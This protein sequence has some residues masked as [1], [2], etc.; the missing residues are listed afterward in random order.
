MNTVNFAST[1]HDPKKQLKHLIEEVGEKLRTPFST[2]SVVYT[3]KTHPDEVAQLE[4]IGYQT[5]KADETVINTYQ[6]A[7]KQACDSK[8]SNILYCDLDRALHWMKTYPDE[9]LKFIQTPIKNDFILFGRTKRAFNT[10]P[11]TQTL[12]E[13]IGNKITSKLLDFPDTRDVLGTT[14][15]LTPAL[16]KQVLEKE[17]SNQYGFYIEWPITFWRS[18]KNPRYIEV[19]GLEWET[20]DRY[21]REI[22]NH[23]LESWKRTFQTPEEWRKRV[24]MLRDFTDTVTNIK[25]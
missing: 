4:E 6:V 3:P 10:H 8:T 11:E 12:T 24:I 18:A 21:R 2:A 14:W 16:A 25:N 13:G 23:G 1:I 7:L 15:L 9:I 17:P 19:E 5:F 20:P 22:Q